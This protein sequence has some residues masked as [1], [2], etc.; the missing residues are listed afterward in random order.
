VSTRRLPMPHG[1][2]SC[3]KIQRQSPSS[4]PPAVAATP[5]A[6]LQNFN[7]TTRFNGTTPFENPLNL[8]PLFVS[9]GGTGSMVSDYSH[10]TGFINWWGWDPV[11]PDRTLITTVTLPAKRGATVLNVSDSCNKSSSCCLLEDTVC[12]MPCPDPHQG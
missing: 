4:W 11:A 1:Q 5:Q 2:L 10:G 3:Q 8:A 6:G 7:G 12:D 9:Q